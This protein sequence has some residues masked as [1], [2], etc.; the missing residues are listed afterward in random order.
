MSL[1]SALVDQRP[2]VPPQPKRT[3]TPPAPRSALAIAESAP[4]H[5]VERECGNFMPPPSDRCWRQ[6]PDSW[7]A[8]PGCAHR[9]D[10]RR[11]NVAAPGKR[12]A[13]A[14][15]VQ[16]AEQYRSVVLTAFQ[17][18]ADTLTAL[19]QDAR[20][21]E[22]GSGSSGRGNGPTLDLAQ[23]QS[24]RRVR[25]LPGFA[26]CGASRSTGADR[27]RAGSSGRFA[28]PAALFQ[29]LGGG[30]WHDGQLT[31]NSK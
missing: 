12:G 30:W 15:Y 11:R 14:A 8:R 20:G 13:R 24:S 25:E 18:V 3:C 29:A 31:R 10:F 21:T 5:H 6:E 17:N 16:A 27:C 22:P 9:P 28:D 7:G 19:E 1:P 26:Q 2:D 4:Q 23:R